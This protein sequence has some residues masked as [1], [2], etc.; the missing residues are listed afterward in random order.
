MNQFSVCFLRE[1]H[2]RFPQ[3][4]T[5][6]LKDQ[7]QKISSKHRSVHPPSRKSPLHIPS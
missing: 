3:P 6:A 4:H 7:E 2:T 5:N 1:V